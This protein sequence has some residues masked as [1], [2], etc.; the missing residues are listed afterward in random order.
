MDETQL[1]HQMLWRKYLA[2][3]EEYATNKRLAEEYRKKSGDSFSRAEVFSN[4]LQAEGL[5]PESPPESL[6]FRPPEPEPTAQ[7]EESSPVSP[8]PFALQT[9]TGQNGNGNGAPINKTHAVFLLMRK[10]ENGLLSVDELFKMSE[11]ARYG[12]SKEDIG[13]VVARQMS[14]GLVE[15]VDG[16]YRQTPEGEKF[17]NF[18]RREVSTQG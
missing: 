16:K 12:V 5:D 8:E 3:K 10:A 2:A 1:F 13:R 4:A 9:P 15:K 17:N 6:G 7:A 11:E 14:R 18:I